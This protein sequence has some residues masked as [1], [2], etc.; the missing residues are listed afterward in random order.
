MKNFLNRVS[1]IA[2]VSALPSA[3]QAADLQ[4]TITGLKTNS[5]QVQV[6][7]FAGPSGF[8]DQATRLVGKRTPGREGQVTVRFTNLQPGNYAIAAFHDVNGDGVLNTNL[9]GIPKEPYGFSN[10]AR[11]PMSPP[12]FKAA[13]IS[14]GSGQVSTIITVK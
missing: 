9:V 7:L 12:D 6:G 14:I 3:S 2:A 11:R 8:P 5:G 1:L 13:R 10:G 4:V